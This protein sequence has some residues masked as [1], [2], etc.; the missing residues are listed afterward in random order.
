MSLY[1]QHLIKYYN[2][3]T[4][5]RFFVS[6]KLNEDQYKKIQKLNDDLK[7]LGLGYK[8]E[9]KSISKA[10]ILSHEKSFRVYVDLL[11]RLHP[12]RSSRRKKGKPVTL[13]VQEK[14]NLQDL[15]TQW[16]RDRNQEDENNTFLFKE[17]N[18]GSNIGYYNNMIIQPW[19]V[20]F[21]QTL[22]NEDQVSE[23]EDLEAVDE[24]GPTR[25]FISQVCKQIG[26]LCISIP[27]KKYMKAP[28]PLPI[29]TKVMVY[30]GA[31]ELDI[32][33]GYEGIISKR[34][35]E[36][37]V[38]TYEVTGDTFVEKSVRRGDL[39]VLL[40]NI[41]LF[42][43]HSAGVVPV[44]DEKLQNEVEMLFQSSKDDNIE[45]E[46]AKED[47]IDIAKKYYRA[48][49]RIMCHCMVSWSNDKT[50]SFDEK[51]MFN[52]KIASEA[53]PSFFRNGEIRKTKTNMYIYINL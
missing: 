3:R 13:K 48:I 12:L 17:L 19:T 41:E 23:K 11:R 28:K 22:L 24:G 42:E 4:Y 47:I 27:C 37:G 44:T 8:K 15:F 18:N 1:W 14:I 31:T 20:N 21:Q 53:L 25:E 9:K 34:V 32:G 29:G 50:L 38:Y 16:Y 30:R 51:K 6:S 46:N 45:A 49:G 2:L 7:C 52:F 33:S 10:E 36:H 43:T 35:Q 40:F 39:D 5:V 26:S